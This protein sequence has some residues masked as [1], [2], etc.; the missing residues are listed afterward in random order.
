MRGPCIG[1]HGS[2]D[3]LAI[4]ARRGLHLRLSR[5]VQEFLAQAGT[6]GTTTVYGSDLM[7]VA[8]LADLRS[9]GSVT[10]FTPSSS[11]SISR[12]RA[13]KRPSMTP[14]TLTR[15]LA[16]LNSFARWGRQRRLWTKNPMSELQGMARSE[17]T[18]A[19]FPRG[20]HRDR[21]GDGGDGLRLRCAGILAMGRL[22]PTTRPDARSGGATLAKVPGPCRRSAGP[23]VRPRHGE[24]EHEAAAS[25]SSLSR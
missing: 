19:T 17:L 25:V 14:P 1:R 16:A 18:R 12:P 3:S 8:A 22:H 20:S 11:T 24:T 9:D 13:Q 6:P 4:P 7:L 10:A 5:A 15:R 2:I 21:G 23:E